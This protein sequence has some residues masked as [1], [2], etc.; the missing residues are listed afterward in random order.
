MAYVTAEMMGGYFT[1]GYSYIDNTAVVCHDPK[2]EFRCDKCKYG[3]YEGIS[4]EGVIR[5]CGE[6][7]CGERGMPACPRG[8]T[9]INN[10]RYECYENSKLSAPCADI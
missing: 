6:D 9:F 5:F 8:I 3:W 2:S 10:N 7:R 4:K 1:P